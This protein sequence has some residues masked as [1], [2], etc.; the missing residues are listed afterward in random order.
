MNGRRW[1][2]AVAFCLLCV[3][4]CAGTRPAARSLFDGR[5]LANWKATDFPGTPGVPRVEDG[6]IVLPVGE[7]MTGITW[8]GGTL[9]T[10]NYELSL[11][12]QRVAGR[13]FFCGITFPVGSSHASF[14]AGGW[15]GQ[16]CGISSLNGDDAANN[17][18]TTTR[19]FELQ[20]W[21]RIV[22]RVRPQRLQV[23][24]DDEPIVDVATTGKHIGVRW[25]V[26]P[27]RP[28]GIA[29]YRTAGTVK[30]IILR[31]LSPDAPAGSTGAE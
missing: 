14:I 4:G 22:I 27:S 16:L 1:N 5:S 24:I 28:L 8:T 21:Y 11:E 17:E 30:N 19:T 7:R 9:P 29:T 10:M 2:I 25:E 31:P 23:L 12:A 6:R 13:D 18:T 15:G 20:R 26:E 3:A